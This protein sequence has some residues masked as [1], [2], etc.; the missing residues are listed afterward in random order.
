MC[1]CDQSGYEFNS[2][3]SV[4]CPKANTR[5]GFHSD[6]V[7]FTSLIDEVIAEAFRGVFLVFYCSTHDLSELA[8]AKCMSKLIRTC[9]EFTFP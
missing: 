9:V 6:H 2:S 1:A 8:M 7:G 3:G 5:M 4:V